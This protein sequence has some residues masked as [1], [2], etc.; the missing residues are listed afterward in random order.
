M[1]AMSFESP[2]TADTFPK[3][4]GIALNNHVMPVSALSYDHTV[5]PAA[6]ALNFDAAADRKLFID[7]RSQGRVGLVVRGL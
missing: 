5:H 6:T 2:R 1:L 7:G 3:C 4:M